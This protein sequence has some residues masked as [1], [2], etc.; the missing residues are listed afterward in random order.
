MVID[1]QLKC[2]FGTSFK[3]VFGP[4]GTGGEVQSM[5]NAGSWL[6]LALPVSVC[7]TAEGGQR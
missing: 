5:D 1:T 2:F 6:T 7:S 3:G 4:K